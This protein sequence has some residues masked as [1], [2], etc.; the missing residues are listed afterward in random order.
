MQTLVTTIAWANRTIQQTVETLTDDLASASRTAASEI[1]ESAD[2]G[3]RRIEALLDTSEKRLSDEVTSGLRPLTGETDR[4]AE[5]QATLAT[6][7]ARVEA[8]MAQRDA[9]TTR[10]DEVAARMERTIADAAALLTTRATHLRAEQRSAVE[11]GQDVA[12]GLEAGTSR[13]GELIAQ[14]AAVTDRLEAATVAA[15]TSR[16]ALEQVVTRAEEL[17]ADA[18]ARRRR[19]SAVPPPTG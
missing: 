8:L 18:A 11:E 19:A 10:R 3:H 5:Q 13:A 2:E 16:Q 6:T 1:K 17:A 9:E 14:L 4:V 7:I 12:R 15:D